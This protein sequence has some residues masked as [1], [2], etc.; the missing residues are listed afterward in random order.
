MRW[1]GA[2]PSLAAS[3]AGDEALMAEATHDLGER[4][5]DEPYRRKL[6]LVHHRLEASLAQLQGGRAEHPYST[7]AELLEDLD[8]VDAALRRQRGRVFAD[9]GL[10]DLRRQV[11]AFDF[12]GYSLD[13]RFHSSRLRE[14][15]SAILRQSGQV[16]GNLD[17]LDEEAAVRL[18]ARAMQQRGPHVGTLALSPD[19]RDLVETVVEMGRAQR[20]ISPRAAESVVISMTHSPVEVMAAMWLGSLVGLVSWSFGE[21]HSSRLD[22]VPLL[23]TIAGL[24]AG[25]A[26]LRRLL[27]QPEYAQQVRARNNLQ[28]VMLG[29]SDSSKDGGYL[30]AQWS[31]YVAHR[32]LARVCDDAG[33]RLRLFHGRG[34]TVSRG[35]GPTHE[36]L[37][38][39]PP[40][41]VRGRVRL[42]EQGEIVHYRYSRAEVAQNHLELVAAAV[43]EASSLQGPLPPEQEAVWETA[44]ARVAADSYRRYRSFVYTDE[45]ERFFTQVTPIG[46]LGQL[47]IGS[48][49]VS[50]GES[51][52]IAD[53]RAIPWVFAWNQTRLMLPTWYGV[54]GSLVAFAEGG[55]ADADADRNAPPPSQTEAALPEPG[56]ARWA[57]LTRCT[58]AGRSSGP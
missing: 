35:G 9:G 39:Q 3:I 47:N 38:A 37:L 18:L 13:V 26:L 45:F 33:V 8:L 11:R 10:F 6:S 31:L 36:A 14:V 4:N 43:W 51:T 48:R 56:A 49:P 5:R 40:G 30:A 42:T 16:E 7:A 54:G 34:G 58:C 27:D 52:R 46:E 29:Y 50:R 17:A 57:L 53:L 44:M 32:E 23:E 41:A 22:L 25:P 28:E 2:D 12:C 19:D 55:R 21:V 1:T 20:A 24:R 15:A